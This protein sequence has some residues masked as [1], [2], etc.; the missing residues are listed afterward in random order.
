MSPSKHQESLLK[1]SQ[2]F[3]NG[4]SP[5]YIY[6]KLIKDGF[7]VDEAKATVESLTHK[8]FLVPEPGEEGKAPV[9][10]DDTE[11]TAPRLTL[12]H[13]LIFGLILI[14]I[15]LALTFGLPDMRWPGFA[16]LVAGPI[17]ILF[18][19]FRASS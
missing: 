12:V 5:T 1:A 14:G 10:S 17:V 2:L 7:G 19:A 8:P 3:D 18:G 4:Y 13:Y 6:E 11:S 15:G 9:Q 16:V